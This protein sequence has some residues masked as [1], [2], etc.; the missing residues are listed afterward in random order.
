MMNI[1]KVAWLC[2][3]CDCD[4]ECCDFQRDAKECK[5]RKIKAELMDGWEAK[6]Q[7]PTIRATQEANRRI[8]GRGAL[9]THANKGVSGA[10]GAHHF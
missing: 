9:F 3:F 10:T 5:M 2:Q 1:M 6:S 7:L 4:W 8:R